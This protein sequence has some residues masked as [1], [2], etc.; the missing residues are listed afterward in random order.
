MCLHTVLSFLIPF[1]FLCLLSLF[2]S[3]LPFFLSIHT[4]VHALLLYSYYICLHMY[5]WIHIENNV[6][7]V[8]I[9]T[10]IFADIHL[11]TFI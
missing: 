3:F 10:Q 5:I 2:S 7:Y 11:F 9:N 4:Y 6:F 8:F 1:I